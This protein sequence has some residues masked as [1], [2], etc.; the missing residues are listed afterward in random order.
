VAATWP[1]GLTTIAPDRVRTVL[2]Q[3]ALAE[4]RRPVPDLPRTLATALFALGFGVAVGVD[5]V[6]LKGDIERMN[7]VFKFSL[8]AWQLFALASGYAAWYAGCALWEARGWRPRPRAG[9]A[10][11][12]LAAT[13]TLGV[14]LL[15]W[16]VLARKK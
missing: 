10:T 1:F 13:A 8:Q 5:V 4:L 11:A 9:R 16:T 12:A 15:G 7:T 2:A 14:L 3:P 6:T